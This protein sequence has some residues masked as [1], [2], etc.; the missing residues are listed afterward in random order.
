[1]ICH[2]C[3]ET[4]DEKE[5]YWRQVIGWEEP[6]QGGGANQIHERKLTGPRA[7]PACIKGL[8]VTPQTIQER[9]YREMM[10]AEAAERQVQAAKLERGACVCPS[11]KGRTVKLRGVFRTVHP[12]G[13]PKWKPWHDEVW[14]EVAERE[15]AT[16]AFTSGG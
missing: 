14:A 13:C 1:M 7:H 3:N 12:R 8:S 9:R 16:K 11:G 10:G 5:P 4:L 15:Q 6:R 2:V